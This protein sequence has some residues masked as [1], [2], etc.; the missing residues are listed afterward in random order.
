[1]VCSVEGGAEDGF[2]KKKTKNV[3]VGIDGA[4]ACDGE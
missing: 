2:K 4:I 1:M 3:G